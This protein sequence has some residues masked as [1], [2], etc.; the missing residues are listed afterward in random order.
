M[1][2]FHASAPPAARRR[3]RTTTSARQADWDKAKQRFE[4]SLEAVKTAMDAHAVV[5]QAMF[6]A[7]KALDELPYPP[8]LIVV[9]EVEIY[10]KDS[11]QPPVHR[12]SSQETRLVTEGEIGGYAG[13]DEALHASM[14]AALRAHRR[15]HGR[16]AGAYQAADAVADAKYILSSAAIDRSDAQLLSLLRTPAPSF[17][18]L[19]WKVE[20]LR[21]A[22]CNEET[23][24]GGWSFVLTELQAAAGKG[25]ALH[26]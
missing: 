8:C 14:V 22:E 10:I 9:T 17:T 7:R 3:S 6:A 5:E 23:E 1:D 15:E 18:E 19:C 25:V 4:R 21:R 2:G 11:H 20:T 26:A 16:L 13:E 12:K 24:R